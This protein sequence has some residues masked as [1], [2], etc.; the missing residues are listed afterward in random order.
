MEKLRSCVCTDSKWNSDHVHIKKQPKGLQPR[1]AR[2]IEE[3]LSFQPIRVQCKEVCS[4][5]LSET[6][7]RGHLQ[8]I[9][10]EKLWLQASSQTNPNIIIVLISELFVLFCGTG[11]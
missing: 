8:R 2:N 7:K 5:M 3:N 6:K 9:Y 1:C 10:S 4:G 11:A